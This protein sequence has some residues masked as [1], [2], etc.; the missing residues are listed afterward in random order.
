MKQATAELKEL[1]RASKYNL[2]RDDVMVILQADKQI[3]F[4]PLDEVDWYFHNYNMTIEQS[5]DSMFDWMEARPPN[6]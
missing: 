4:F 5:L 6:R 3:A 2:L 1:L